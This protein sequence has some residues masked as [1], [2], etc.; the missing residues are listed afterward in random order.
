MM[1]KSS[2]RLQLVLNESKPKEKIILDYLAETFNENN[3]IK[4]IL[5][6][7]IVSGG[8][9]KKVKDTQFKVNNSKVAKSN[10]KKL[11]DTKIESKVVKD[12]K[13]K[14]KILTNTHSE[15]KMVKN[16]EGDDITIDLSQF[17]DE[18]VEIKTDE[19][20]KAEELKQKNLK[21]LQQFM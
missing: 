3:A 4:E 11:K 8:K 7:F 20:N 12:S 14:Q 1:A 10:S 15:S 6:N 17:S 18:P 21:T 5:Y 19:T 16:T 2:R 9:L 13:S